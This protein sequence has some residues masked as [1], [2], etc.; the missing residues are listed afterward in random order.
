MIHYL[1]AGAR[2]HG[3]HFRGREIRRRARFKTMSVSYAA[4]WRLDVIGGGPSHES[5]SPSRRQTGS[6]QRRRVLATG[7]IRHAEQRGKQR[8]QQRHRRRT[9]GL[10]RRGAVVAGSGARAGGVAEHAQT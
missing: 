2:G 3:R 8:D 7:R 6:W 10:D 1:A 5:S 4:T 9:A